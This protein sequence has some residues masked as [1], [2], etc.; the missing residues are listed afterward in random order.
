[1][2]RNDKKYKW[3]TYCN[4]VQ[5][6]W[7]FRWKDGHEEWKI[8]QGKKPSVCFFNPATNT[9]IYCYYLMTTSDESMEEEAKGGDDSQNN[10][11]ISLSRFEL[12][13][14][15]LKRDFSPLLLYIFLFN[16][17]DVA[18]DPAWEGELLDME[19]EYKLQP[20]SQ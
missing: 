6:A 15:L 20:V 1:M 3:C 14:W 10:D 5:G 17:V 18:M 9:V 19:S 12:L 11:F 16:D 8:K 4:N 2:T 13:K 7:G